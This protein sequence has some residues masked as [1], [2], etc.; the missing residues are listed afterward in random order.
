LGIYALFSAGQI[1][2]VLVASFTLAIAGVSASRSLHS[3][4]LKNILRSPMS[5]F[6]TT[7]LGRVLNRFS[8]DVYLV[9]EVVPMSIRTFFFT[10]LRIFSTILVIVIAT[11][12]FA[13]VILPLSIFYSFIQVM[14][15]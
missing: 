6:D 3:K 5:F 7:P 10:G 12:T 14:I 15:Y 9:D 2:S 4:M 8:K 13:I 11:P 1:V